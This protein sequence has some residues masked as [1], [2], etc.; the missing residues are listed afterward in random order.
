MSVAS[1]A[2]DK[3]RREAAYATRY[4]H[5]FPT[6]DAFRAWQENQIASWVNTLA[7]QQRRAELE[8]TFPKGDPI[9]TPL[10]HDL[11]PLDA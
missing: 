6:M 8:A 1:Q 5:G 10:N 7:A 11:D 4:Q 3:A 9:P 2:R